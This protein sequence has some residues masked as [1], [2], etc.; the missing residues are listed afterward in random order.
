MYIFTCVA[1]SQWTAGLIGFGNKPVMASPCL[2]V[3]WIFCYYCKKRKPALEIWG[4]QDLFIFIENFSHIF[5]FYMVWSLVFSLHLMDF[6]LSWSFLVSCLLCTESILI[7]FIAII[8]FLLIYLFIAWVY[9]K[10]QSFPLADFQ[11]RSHL[12]LGLLFCSEE[13]FLSFTAFF[14]FYVHPH[15]SCRL[16]LH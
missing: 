4:E 6:S 10:W 2:G 11:F 3:C 7:F 1:S 15:L 9:A 16:H 8:S 14:F 5:W 13:S 12:S